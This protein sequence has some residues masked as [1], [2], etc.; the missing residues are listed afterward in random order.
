MTPL[1]RTNTRDRSKAG[2][3]ATPRGV[4]LLSVQE[5]AVRWGVADQTVR[6]RIARGELRAYRVGRLIRI[7]PRDAERSVHPVVPSDLYDENVQ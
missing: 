6:E 4:R 5:L 2:N 1:K 7:D 3:H